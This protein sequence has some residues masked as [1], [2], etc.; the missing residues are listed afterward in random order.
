MLEH[1]KLP[2][3]EDA[4]GTHFPM[5]EGD[6]HVRVFVTRAALEGQGSAIPVG[7]AMIRFDAFR[8]IY[9]AVAK[10]KYQLG[11]FKAS[12]TIDLADLNKFLDARRS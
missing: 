12:M 4:R 9:E 8:D 2:G 1:M 7:E 5:R 10:A 3:Y 11:A 6:K